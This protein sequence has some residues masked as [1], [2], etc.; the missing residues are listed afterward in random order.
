MDIG[1]GCLSSLPNSSNHYSLTYL[2]PLLH[3]Q[4]ATFQENVSWLAI[5]YTIHC[6][7][8]DYC[9]EDDLPALTRRAPLALR[10][11]VLLKGKTDS[12]FSS[13]GSFS[14][15]RSFSAQ[16]SFFA[17]RT[18]SIPSTWQWGGIPRGTD[19]VRGLFIFLYP[20][21]PDFPGS[22]LCLIPYSLFIKVP[23]KIIMLAC[24]GTLF[25]GVGIVR[26][27]ILV[28]RLEG[29]TMP[30]TICIKDPCIKDRHCNVLNA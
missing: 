24:E 10:S 11:S 18:F 20:D 15:Q 9:W 26:A 16:H 13:Q 25:Q 6:K 21:S 19:D 17:Q 27:I 2:A 28:D 12:H 7:L 23:D 29:T 8:D 30:F 1:S 14:A 5:I 22:P 4:V 3:C